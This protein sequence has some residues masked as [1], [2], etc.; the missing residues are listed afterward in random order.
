[1]ISA[2]QLAHADDASPK[3]AAP[4][5]ETKDPLTGNVF[6][7]VLGGYVNH[8]DGSGNNNGGVD[9]GARF[10]TYAG[11]IGGF[12]KLALAISFDRFSISPVNHISFAANSLLVD[13]MIKKFLN[14]GFYFGGQ[15]GLYQGVISNDFTGVNRYN[16]LAVGALLGYEFDLNKEWAIGLEGNYESLTKGTGAGNVYTGTYALKGLASITYNLDTHETAKA[17]YNSSTTEDVGYIGVMGGFA[18]QNLSSGQ[19]SNTS[20]SQFAYGVHAGKNVTTLGNFS[21]VAIGVS[22]DRF[23]VNADEPTIS[24]AYMAVLGQVLFREVGGSG[25]FFGPEAG[26]GFLTFSSTLNPT[27]VENTTGSGL[28]YGGALG[29]EGYLTQHVSVGPEF[30]F[31]KYNGG[32]VT[33]SNISTSYAGT[34]VAKFLFDVN[35]HF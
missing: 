23:V 32:S 9:Y 12:G 27:T 1:M 2:G 34:T 33:V 22:A 19:S 31:D 30:H 25:F 24:R 35:Y 28:V 5:A 7:S 11:D 17:H 21:K 13:V 8:N 18:L 16:T 15:L 20:N 4:A 26:I 6:I 3:A 10:G 14:T 29:Y